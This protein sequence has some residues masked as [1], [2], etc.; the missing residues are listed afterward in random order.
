LLDAGPDSADSQWFI[1][2]GDNAFI[3]EAKFTV[4]AEVVKGMDV[5]DKIATLRVE[6]MSGTLGAPFGFM[7][8]DLPAGTDSVAREHLII[9]KRAYRL[10][11]HPLLKPYQCSFGSPGDTLTEFC[12]SS[13]TFPVLVSGV[14]YEG[15]LQYIPGRTGLVFSV[16]R[17]KLKVINDT[18][19]VRATFANGVLTIPSLRNGTRAFTNVRLN[20]TSSNPLEFTVDSFTPR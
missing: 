2:T 3:D 18:G 4:F 9:V 12:G 7:P 11:Q 8:L 10:E 6:D 5:V 15:T 19:Q 17:S 13:T 1:N 14:L 20:M 16:D